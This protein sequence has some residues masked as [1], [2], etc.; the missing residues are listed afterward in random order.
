MEKNT[1]DH[2]EKEFEAVDL[3]IFGQYTGQLIVLMNSN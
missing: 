2:N 1:K 3:V